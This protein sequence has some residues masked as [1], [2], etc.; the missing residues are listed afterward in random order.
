MQRLHLLADGLDDS[1]TF[2]NLRVEILYGVER[3]KELV[4]AGGDLGEEVHFNLGGRA[5][6]GARTYASA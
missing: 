3:G 6:G 4:G 5:C 2:T 1:E